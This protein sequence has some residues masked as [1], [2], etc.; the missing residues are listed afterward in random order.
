ML[1]LSTAWYSQTDKRMAPTLEAIRRM[2]FSAVEIGVSGMHC[3]LNY[4]LKLSK[5]QERG[6]VNLCSGRKIFH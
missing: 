4:C 2:G 1:S 5:A 3:R 6:T